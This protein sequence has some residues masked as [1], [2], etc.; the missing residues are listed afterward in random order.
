[1]S[2]KMKIP[3]LISIHD[4]VIKWKHFLLFSLIYAFINGWV[5]TREAG[6]VRRRRAHYDVTVMIWR[7]TNET[8]WCM[9]LSNTALFTLALD[10][11]T[12]E[13]HTINWKAK[14]HFAYFAN[15]KLWLCTYFPILTCIARRK[16]ENVLHILNEY[17]SFIW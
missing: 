1:M 11:P 4:D 12:V 15:T 10:A 7:N 17:I 16:I 9:I 14:M 5:N 8:S 13:N 2:S 6:D 3:F